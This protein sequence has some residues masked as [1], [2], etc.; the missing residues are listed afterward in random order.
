MAHSSLELSIGGKNYK[1]KAINERLNVFARGLFEDVKA[2]GDRWVKKEAFVP[3][4]FFLL[5]LI[6][7]LIQ[8]FF[9]GQ[10]L[11]QNQESFLKNIGI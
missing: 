6:F 1:S 7:M 9:F 2:E 10:F 4:L 5:T 11:G 8:L 3:E